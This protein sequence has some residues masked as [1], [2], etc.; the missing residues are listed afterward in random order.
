[1]YVYVWV[2]TYTV[3]G[4]NPEHRSFDKYQTREECVQALAGIR[5]QKKEEGKKIA[6][7]CKLVLKEKK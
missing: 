3:L 7:E 6:G 5:Q 4:S 2:L 1:M